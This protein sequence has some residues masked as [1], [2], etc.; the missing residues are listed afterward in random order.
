MENI[1]MISFTTA[2]VNHLTLVK[3]S[4][5]LHHIKVFQQ[6]PCENSISVCLAWV[7]L[8]QKVHSG[9]PVTSYG[10]TQTNIL[11]NLIF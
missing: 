9:F 8:D 5:R 4:N 6:S 11:A 3:Y 10:K 1:N 7:W 2:A